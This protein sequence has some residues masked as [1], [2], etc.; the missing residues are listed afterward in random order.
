MSRISICVGT[1]KI[2]HLP[3]SFFLSLINLLNSQ[4]ISTVYW[5]RQEHLLLFC[6]SEGLFTS[7][8]S[9]IGKMTKWRHTQHTALVHRCKERHDCNWEEFLA[10]F[11]LGRHTHTVFTLKGKFSTLLF[12][13]SI[14][15]RHLLKISDVIL[16]AL[17]YFHCVIVHPNPYS[18]CKKRCLSIKQ[19]RGGAVYSLC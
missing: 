1:K 2:R 9:T 16:L 19:P 13:G 5:S 4:T 12:T 8:F 11:V 6:V 14:H 3:T 18:G 15:F 17:M 10:V 7:E